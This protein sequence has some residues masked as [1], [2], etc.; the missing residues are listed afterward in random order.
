LAALSIVYVRTTW[1]SCR[2][3]EE[4]CCAKWPQSMVHC[5]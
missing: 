4:P 2:L 5:I 1:S 3:V